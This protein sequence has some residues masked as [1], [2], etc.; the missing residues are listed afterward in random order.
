MDS[1][2]VKHG[3]LVDFDLM[4]LT[5][6]YGE[7]RSAMK[8]SAEHKVRKDE[9]RRMRDDDEMSLS[10][11]EEEKEKEKGKRIPDR[12]GM[13]RGLTKYLAKLPASQRERMRRQ[14]EQPFSSMGRKRSKKLEIA[15]HREGETHMYPAEDADK[16]RKEVLSVSLFPNL[17][18]K[19]NLLVSM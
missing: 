8:M 12:P 7:G 17:Y 11:K 5:E 16:L 4:N 9:E 13:S 3:E 10:E 18:N 2:R 19:Q 14:A 1:D 15:K 6:N